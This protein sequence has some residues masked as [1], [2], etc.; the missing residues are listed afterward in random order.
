M[1]N[2]LGEKT[3]EPLL[4]SRFKIELLDHK[5]STAFPSY[6][7]NGISDKKEDKV[8]IRTYLAVLEGYENLLNE[9]VVQEINLYWLDPAG[10]PTHSLQYSAVNLQSY[11]FTD[12]CWQE[13]HS[14]EDITKLQL[15]YEYSNRKWN[16]SYE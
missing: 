15:T 3:Y 6:L 14:E 11:T 7:V 9:D 2:E 8:E 10:N 5:G 12:L 13:E 16:G 4:N 1:S